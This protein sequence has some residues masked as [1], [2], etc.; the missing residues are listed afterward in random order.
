MTAAAA[1]LTQTRSSTVAGWLPRQRVWLAVLPLIGLCA[2]LSAQALGQPEVAAWAWTLAT[3]LVL[4]ILASQIVTSL[5]RGD[6]GLDLVAL[7]SMSGALAL[8]QPLA[9][10]VIALMYAGGQSLEAYAAGRAGRTMTSL[11]ARQ[12]RTA[13]REVGGALRD[14]PL[15]QLVPGDRILVRVGDVV[16]VDGRVASGRAVLDRSSLT[17]EALPAILGVNE[18]VLSGTVNV[19]TPFA[20]IADRRAADSTYAGIV[21][22]V[23]A[24][25]ARKAP[26]TRLADRYGLAFLGLT[27]LLAGGAWLAAGDPVRA[28]AVLVVATPCPLI[29]AVPVALVSGLSRAAQIG[30]LIKGGGA[31]ETLAKIRVLVVDKTGTLTHGSARLVS[32]RVLI[33]LD[34]AEVLRL[35]AS[36]DQASGHPVAR[37]LVEEARR[38]GLALAQ[39]QDVTEMPGEGVT[40]SVDRRHVVLGGPRL[41]R[42]QGLSFEPADGA[43]DLAA[44]AATVL[45]AIDGAP[46][47]VLAFADPLRA[48][49]GNTLVRLRACGIERVVLATGDQRAVAQAL[50]AGL[51]IDRVAADL[52]PTAKTETV[53]TERRIGPVMMVGDGVNDAPALAAADLGVA[54]G[55]RGAAAAAEAADVVLLVDSLAPLPAAIRIAKR[56]R[57]IALQSVWVG[58]G[59]SLGGMVAAA[60]GHLSPIRGALLQEFIDVA[61]ILNAMRVLVGRPDRGAPTTGSGP[62]RP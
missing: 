56:A 27:L 33:D 53:A 25:Q 11:I 37:A 5:A 50:A 28:L 61:V 14:V 22:L 38:R 34:E 46:A 18:P 6:V 43:G 40:G 57:A 4:A 42:R 59:L 29:L 49:G 17:G 60:L 15:A 2:G 41:M 10:A 9:G 51:P 12:P 7:L 35:A 13:L 32:T 21:R 47:A 54:L 19:G 16:P 30:V 44:A 45:V 8:S 58:L 20:L 23:E 48:D 24:A 36:L 39:P 1:E 26:M 62:H 55:A 52:D 3:L 31:L